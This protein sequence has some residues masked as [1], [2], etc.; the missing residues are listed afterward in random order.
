MR[1]HSIHVVDAAFVQYDE[2]IMRLSCFA[3]ARITV[4]SIAPQHH[5]PRRSVRSGASMSS[6]AAYEPIHISRDTMCYP[7]LSVP[8]YQTVCVTDVFDDIYLYFSLADA[9]ACSASNPS[10]YRKCSR[11]I[12]FIVLA[13]NAVV[14]VTPMS[15][16]I[17]SPIDSWKQSLA[18]SG[19]QCG[20]SS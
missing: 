6:T 5:A 18:E 1:D 9:C 4:P 15:T 2:D 3:I 16:M 11:I 17:A 8:Q 13:P 7:L 19:W 12:L 10:S 20:R 14:T